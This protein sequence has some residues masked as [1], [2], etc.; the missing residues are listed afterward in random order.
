MGW[1]YIGETLQLYS[2]DPSVSLQPNRKGKNKK[3]KNSLF[4]F[5][6]KFEFNVV[7]MMVFQVWRNF[8]DPYSWLPVCHAG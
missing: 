1:P 4:I 6:H 2:Q 5:K 7:E 3:V 8:Q